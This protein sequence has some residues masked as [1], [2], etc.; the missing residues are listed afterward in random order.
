MPPKCQA[1]VER[2]TGH[3]TVAGMRR[4]ARMVHTEY[5]PCTRKA[6]AKLG[7]L[8][9]CTQHVKLAR[10]GL[11]DEDGQVAERGAMRDVRRYPDKFRGGLYAWARDLEP[12]PLPTAIVAT[13]RPGEPPR[14]LDTGEGRILI[15]FTTV[16]L[17]VILNYVPTRAVRERCI[18]A[19]DLLDPEA[20]KEFTVE[21]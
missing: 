4:G 1:A 14:V 17:C 10:E 16:E 12:E 9:L 19:L 2:I 11:V 3:S 8:C 5:G 18:T 7:P 21:C 15:G 20:A 13:T 6:T